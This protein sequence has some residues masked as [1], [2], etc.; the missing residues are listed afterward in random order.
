MIRSSMYFGCWYNIL[1][2]FGKYYV[3]LLSN[4]SERG[5]LIFYSQLSIIVYLKPFRGSTLNS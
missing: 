5:L 3:V 1:N 2:F 4:Q